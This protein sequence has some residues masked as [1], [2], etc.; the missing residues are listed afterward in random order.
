MPA[1]DQNGE[2]VPTFPSNRP[3]S[4]ELLPAAWRDEIAGQVQTLG[5]VEAARVNQGW[6]ASNATGA[7][8]ESQLASWVNAILNPVSTPFSPPPASVGNPPVD[9]ISSPVVIPPAVDQFLNQPP[10]V[11]VTGLFAQFSNLITGL[12][13]T[14]RGD[15]TNVTVAPVTN[16]DISYNLTDAAT[17]DFSDKSTTN[18]DASTNIL[19][20]SAGEVNDLIVNLLDRLP[21]L[22]SVPSNGNILSPANPPA[23]YAPNPAQSTQ[24]TGAQTIATV[25]GFTGG[26]PATAGLN[27]PRLAMFAAIGLGV[28]FLVKRFLK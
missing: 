13:A 15:T 8:E 27:L 9:V 6:L 24:R 2:P 17:Y 25:T 16:T 19:G 4:L 10:P 23:G 21:G 28:W 22:A 18:V 5:V 11:D 20:F 3:T 26:S 12:M 1:L 7:P 14:T